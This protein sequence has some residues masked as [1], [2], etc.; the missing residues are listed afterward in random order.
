MALGCCM[1]P[2]HAPE[3]F[4]GYAVLTEASPEASILCGDLLGGQSESWGQQSE[5]CHQRVCLVGSG[6]CRAAYV[7]EAGWYT[8]ELGAPCELTNLK[9]LGDFGA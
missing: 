3:G 5:E 8:W 2:V 7:W 9:N 1:L 6:G 4:G